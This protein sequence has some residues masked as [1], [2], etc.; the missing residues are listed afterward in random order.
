ML[1]KFSIF[2]LTFLVLTFILSL[3]VAAAQRMAVKVDLANVR[4]APDKNA[5]IVW[6]VTR[7]HPFQIL[8]TQGDWYKC[9]DFEGDS[10]WIYKSLLN[11]TTTVITIKENCN[12][13]SGPGAKNPVIFIV[14]REVPL[15][16]LK[17]QGR[18]LQIVHEDGDKGWIHASLVW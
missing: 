12:V 15:K 9:K 10:G 6:Q 18:W 2:A 13:R 14:D 1:K 7:Y 17:R 8:E 16:V 11:R 5:E 4:S 3:P